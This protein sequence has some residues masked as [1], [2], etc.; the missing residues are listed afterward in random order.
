[1]FGT[2]SAGITGDPLTGEVVTIDP[3][4]QSLTSTRYRDI[5]DSLLPKGPLPTAT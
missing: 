4:T 3:A 1:M 5:V 2:D